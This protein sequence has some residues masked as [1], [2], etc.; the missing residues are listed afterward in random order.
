[1]CDGGILKLG[2]GIFVPYRFVVKEEKGKVA[3]IAEDCECLGL[4]SCDP[5]FH[6]LDWLHVEEGSRLDK[7]L[8]MNPVYVAV[9]R[10][11]EPD[12]F[13][14]NQGKDIAVAKLEVKLKKAMAGRRKMLAKELRAMA[15]RLVS[16]S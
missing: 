13:D 10:C 9:A 14:V 11:K 4:C 6:S 2:D 3:A 8:S 12:V 16:I 5:A 1:M 15:E 7:D